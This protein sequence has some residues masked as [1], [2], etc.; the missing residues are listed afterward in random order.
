[1]KIACLFRNAIILTALAMLYGCAAMTPEETVE[2]LLPVKTIAVLPTEVLLEGEHQNSVTIQQREAGAA[3]IET[4][5]ADYFKGWEGIRIVSRHQQEG[6]AL[7][8]S[9]TY[10]AGAIKA[11]RQLNCD[12][13]LLTTVNRYLPR[14]GTNYSVNRPASV[15]FDYRLVAVNNGQTLCSGVFDETQKSLSENIFAFS[16]ATSRGFRWIT[17]EELA[18]EGLHKKL[19]NCSYL[20]REGQPAK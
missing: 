18:T 2:E 5:L 8:H 15:S 13:V 16:R 20:K 14:N 4:L 19:S 1:M 7:D 3:I 6:L 10:L 9:D 11:G 17:A 12:A